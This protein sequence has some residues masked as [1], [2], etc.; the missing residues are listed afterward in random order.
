MLKQFVL[1]T[2]T[3]PNLDETRD[4][5]S[6]YQLPDLGNNALMGANVTFDA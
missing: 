6:S 3:V 4:L 1:I 2:K 5:F